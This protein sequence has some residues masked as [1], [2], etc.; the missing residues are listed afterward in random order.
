MLTNHDAVDRAAIA[1]EKINGPVLLLSATRDEFW[2]STEMSEL[3]VTRLRKSGFPHPF[4]HVA[5]EGD[6]G[7]P[8]E[9]VDLV[10]DFLAANF[11]RESVAGCPR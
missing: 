4:E 11:L 5:I 6:H 7:S 8:Q 2:P 10:E 3:I 9:R 1:V